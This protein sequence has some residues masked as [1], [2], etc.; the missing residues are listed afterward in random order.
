MATRRREIFLASHFDAFAELRAEIKRLIEGG[1]VP[2]QVVDLNDGRADPRAVLERC[3]ERVREC[4]FMLLLLN[5]SYGNSAA[6]SE[7]S[8]VHL[9]YKAA[10]AARKPVFA[11]VLDTAAPGR[12]RGGWS[13]DPRMAALQGALLE[14]QTVAFV[15]PDLTV[16]EQATTI[17]LHV[18]SYFRERSEH[19][20]DGS[21]DDPADEEELHG[22]DHAMLT[23]LS[24]RYLER[25]DAWPSGPHSRQV[26]DI[27]ARPLET[28]AAEH[29]SY[30][31]RAIRAVE[32]A[33]AARHLR[34]ALKLRPL[35]VERMYWLAHILAG[36]RKPIHCRE[37]MHKAQRA[38]RLADADGNGLVAAACYVVASRAARHIGHEDGLKL[39]STAHQVAPWLWLTSF[40]LGC[41]QASHKDAK[42]ALHC[43]RQAFELRPGS[44]L[45]ID[46]EPAFR[47]LGE[48]YQAFRR[49]L[50][51]ETRTR[52]TRIHDA[53][54]WMRSRLDAAV[55]EHPES[56]LHVDDVQR[57]VIELV[58]LGRESARRQVASL[59]AAAQALAADAGTLARTSQLVAATIGTAVPGLGARLAAGA[60]VACGLIGLF[61][62]SIAFQGTQWTLWR[63]AAAIGALLFGGGAAVSGRIWWRVQRLAERA[64]VIVAAVDRFER[65]SL[66]KATFTRT[67][68]IHRARAGECVRMSVDERSWPGGLTGDVQIL[69]PDLRHLAKSDDRTGNQYG[70][71]RVRAALDAHQPEVCRWAAYFE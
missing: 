68:T 28:A 27:L 45:R 42:E 55:P 62:M 5:E 15:S 44:I 1:A 26:V 7:E 17:Y 52:V 32:P 21:S 70:L 38:G 47:A 2:L 11:F 56:V 16:A 36:T 13:R 51:D 60:T 22:L 57:D 33:V 37:A 48:P 12:P 23:V 63:A 10:V 8:Y 3:R 59:R 19:G 20:A 54:Q 9:E 64:T 61:C 18:N 6:G 71:F 49:K 25:S 34:E 30:A 43:A 65:A 35:H 4:D 29:A 40:E 66:E 46:E 67:R 53:E 14:K 31:L 41:Q 50:R 58:A 69:P 39:A 24:A